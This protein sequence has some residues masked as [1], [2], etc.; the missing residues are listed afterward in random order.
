MMGADKSFA[1]WVNPAIQIM[2]CCI[3][4]E[5]LMIKHLPQELSE[6]TSDCIEIVNL[7]KAKSLNSRIFSI[8]CEEMGSEYQSLLFY[9]SVRWLSREKVLARLLNSSAK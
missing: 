6:T 4:R 9:T 3:H 8:L 5:A 7:I 2:Q 1:T